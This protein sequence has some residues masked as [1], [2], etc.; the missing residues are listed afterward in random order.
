MDHGLLFERG[1]YENLIAYSDADYAGDEQTRH[2][3]S[4][5]VFFSGRSIMRASIKQQIVTLSTAETECVAATEAA[6][7]LV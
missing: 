5:S 4:G 3:S 6:K 1:N 7:E 2:S